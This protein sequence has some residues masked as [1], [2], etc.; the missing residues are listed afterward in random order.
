M[1]E[2]GKRLS[3][4][5]LFPVLVLLCGAKNLPPIATFGRSFT[6][7]KMTNGAFGQPLSFLFLSDG[8]RIKKL[9]KFI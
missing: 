7:F 3:G 6:A 1:F 2:I 4:N 5:L 9:K 8:K